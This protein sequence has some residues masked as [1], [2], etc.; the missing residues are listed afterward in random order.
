[1]ATANLFGEPILAV[2]ENDHCR[3]PRWLY[4][5]LDIEFAFDLDPCPLHLAPTVDGL[6]LDWTGRRVFCNPPYSDILPWVDKALESQALTVFL[7]PA[8]FDARWCRNL[9]EAKAEFRFFARAFNFEAHD[10]T[11][12]HPV[13]GAMLA[14]VNRLYAPLFPLAID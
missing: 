5:A 8:R 12:R 13:G 4:D 9:R 3:T 10:G 7:I 11:E 6:Q 2:K 14:I 1:M